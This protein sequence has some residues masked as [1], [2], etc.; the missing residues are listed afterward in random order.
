MKRFLPY[1]LLILAAG[2]V[3]ASI[4]E[5][6]TF[7]LSTLHSGSTLTGTFALSNSPLAGDTASVLLSFSDPGDYSASPLAATITIGNGTTLT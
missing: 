6:I 5:T 4:L 1:V 2:K 7:D 3:E